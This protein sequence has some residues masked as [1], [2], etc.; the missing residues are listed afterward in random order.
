MVWI[1]VDDHYDEHPKFA[2]AGPLGVALW[3]AGM[4]YCN[5]NLTDGHVPWA[6]ARNLVSWLYLDETGPTQIYVGNPDSV[7]EEGAV[8]SPYV[9]ELLIS[10]GLWT[11]V[12]GGYHVHDYEHY[13]PTRE[14]VEAEKAQKVAAGR[15]GG[16]AAAIA[17]AKANG[18]A[19]A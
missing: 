15:A 19:G 11:E 2:R 5:R 12:T 18:K 14:Q 17:R 13:Q 4:A 1:K 16:I 7:H 6:V 9:I 3:L 8:T 10:S